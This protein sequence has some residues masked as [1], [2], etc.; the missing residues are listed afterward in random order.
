LRF[1]FVELFFSQPA[2]DAGK[3]SQFATMPYDMPSDMLSDSDISS[4]FT[5]DR[6]NKMYRQ[7]LQRLSQTRP[8]H[9]HETILSRRLRGLVQVLLVLTV[10]WAPTLAWAQDPAPATPAAPVAPAKPTILDIPLPADSSAVRQFRSA[11][12]GEQ[13]AKLAGQPRSE[14]EFALAPMPVKELT[15]RAENAVS[16]LQT[17][18]TALSTLIIEGERLVRRGA[19]TE[20]LE[21]DLTRRGE[22]I[23]EFR[24]ELAVRATILIDAAEAKGADLTE[25]RTYVSVVT[26]L[27]LPEPSSASDLSDAELAAQRVIRRVREEP[28]VHERDAP[29]SVSISELVEEL[30]PLRREQ[31]EERVNAWLAILQRQ[32]RK[33]IR[34]DIALSKTEEQDEKEVIAKLATEQQQVVNDTVERLQAVLEVFAKR[35]GDTAVASQYISNAT[36]QRVNL[37]DPAVFYAQAKAWAL[38]PSGGLQLAA[39]LGKFFLILFVVWIVSRVIGGIVGAAVKRVPDSSSL[40]QD[41]LVSGSR[42]IVMVI[43]LLVAVSALG[44]NITPLAAAIGA[45]GLVIGLALQ[46][47]L[48]NFASGIMILMYRPFDVGDIV[49]AG[50]VFGK[51]EAMTLVSTR[52]LTFDNQVNWVPND[53]IWN[54][55]ITNATA[56]K[57]RRVDMVFGIGYSDD[58]AVAQD[59]IEKAVADHPKVLSDPAPTIRVNEL[60]DNSVNFVVRPWARTGDYWDVYWDLMRTIKERFD[61]EGINIPFP[62]R[63]LHLSGPIEVVMSAPGQ[64]QSGSGTTDASAGRPPQASPSTAATSSATKEPGPAG[65]DKDDDEEIES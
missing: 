54:N 30:Q 43:G 26:N 23:F 31:L 62:Q 10:F 65:K 14:L 33:R 3:H 50:G 13:A 41:F 37:R 39:N 61:A 56:L 27:D 64:T 21:K 32:V 6:R 4:T 48:S 40:L 12:A 47:T 29:W 46:G 55:V 35:G 34:M 44:V 24:N 58:M 52:I 51:V 49:N 15:G 53:A 19:L 20:E 7:N 16:H 28:P 22:L 45:A 42:R 38:S 60:G 63:D 5:N 1:I 9:T 25:S 57:T 2:N 18:A 59:I 36:G 11:L 17:V 8:A